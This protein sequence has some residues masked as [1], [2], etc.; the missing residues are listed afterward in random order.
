M[1]EA[2]RREGIGKRRDNYR[3]QDWGI[4]RQRY[5]GSPIPVI[6]CEDCGVVPVPD[7][8]L[9]VVLPDDLVPDGRAIRRWRTRSSSSAPCPKCGGPARRETDTMDTFV[10]SSWYFFRYATPATTG[11]I[12]TRVRTTGCRW[13]STSAAS[14]T[15]SCTCC[16]RA[17]GRA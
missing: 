10:E 15:R 17:S 16:I 9:P 8:Q 12:R 11:A 3:L 5:W 7:D 4:S 14:S 6:H 13:T 2:A 1:A